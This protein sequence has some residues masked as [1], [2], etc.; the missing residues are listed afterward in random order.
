MGDN[1]VLIGFMAVGKT[2]VGELLALKLGTRFFDVDRVIS[3]RAGMTV[4]DIFGREGEE[5]FRELELLVI[6]ELGNET[7][8]VVSVGGGAPCR[9]ETGEAIAR[10][11]M[12]AWLRS[13]A[14]SILA[15]VGDVSTRPMLSG[16]SDVKARIAD[17]LAEREDHYRRIAT[18][19]VT[20]DGRS[21]AE[22]A[23]IVAKE[24]L[25]WRT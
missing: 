14:E 22:I 2:V 12:V 23:S 25:A 7:G 21:P 18:A 20:T 11:G 8:C 1:V 10:L 5:R 16:H 13:S 6:Q 15:R 4:A 9:K 19:S 24:Y 17:L 3:V